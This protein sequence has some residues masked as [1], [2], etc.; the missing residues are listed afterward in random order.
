MYDHILQITLIAFGLK[1]IEEHQTSLF[2][3]LNLVKLDLHLH[4]K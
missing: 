3:K 1:K 2:A 4:I